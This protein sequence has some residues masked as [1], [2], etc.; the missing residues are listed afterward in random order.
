[1]IWKNIQTKRRM[2]CGLVADLV[3]AIILMILLFIA[4]NGASKLPC[5]E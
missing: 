3:F 2:K 5:D 4:G 1:V